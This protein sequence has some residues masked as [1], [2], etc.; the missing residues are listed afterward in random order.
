MIDT[1]IVL[2]KRPLA[3]RVK[4]RLSPPLTGQQA[5]DVA[6]AALA[7]T[8]AVA[9]RTPALRHVLAFD[10]PAAP[11]LPPEWIFYKQPAGSL[12]SRIAAAFAEAGRGTTVLI[13]MDTPHLRPEMLTAFDPQRY[14]A[15]LGRAT[16]GGFWAIGLRDP[17]AARAVIEG[18]PMSTAHTGDVQLHRL[19]AHALHVQLLGELT[20]VDT[21]DDADHVAALAPAGLFA[22]TL[23]RVRPELVAAR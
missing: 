14:H 12:D 10:G 9:A 2:A 1:L 20:D 22:E 5:A 11:W 21:I 18:V 13:G 7:D 23:R 6:A 15:C 19:R 16:D 17:A 8:L 4:T 3:G